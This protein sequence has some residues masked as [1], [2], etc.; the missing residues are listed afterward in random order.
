MAEVKW[1]KLDVS[2]PDN[3]K[4]KRIRKM[5]DGN[6]IILF[7]VF[8]LSRAG[9]SNQKGGLFFTE[10]VPYTD[11]D[12][13]ADFDFTIEFVRFAILTLEKYKMIEVY[14]DIIFIKNWDEYQQMDKLEKIKEQNRI[15]QANYREKQKQIASGKLEENEKVTQNNAPVTLPV[16]QNNAADI[17]LDLELDL[18]LENNNNNNK[19][20]ESKINVHSFYQ[21]NYGVEN[22]FISED[23]EYWVED[24][25][26][27]VVLYALQLGAELTTPSYKYAKTIMQN[28][29]TKNIDT[30]EAAKAETMSHNRKTYQGKDKGNESVKGGES[31]GGINF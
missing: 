28:W 23:L 30:I 31:Y 4:V 3:K 6:N 13:A 10:S 26:A 18:E 2:F 20:A 22:S 14:E 1:I 16:T 25:T 21:E 11:E 27:E 7:W 5:P 24:L 17:E 15:R 9:E 12:F 19:Q 8:L 29:A